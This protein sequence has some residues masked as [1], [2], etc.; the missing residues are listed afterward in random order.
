MAFLEQ[1]LQML[2]RSSHI[3]QPPQTLSALPRRLLGLVMFGHLPAHLLPLV[4]ATCHQLSLSCCTHLLAISKLHRLR[5]GLRYRRRQ[6]SAR[7]AAT[8]VPSAAPFVARLLAESR[9]NPVPEVLLSLRAPLKN[10]PWQHVRATPS[11][12]LMRSLSEPSRDSLA[13]LLKLHDQMLLLGEQLSTGAESAGA[14]HE[15]LREVQQSAALLAAK[16]LKSGKDEA[17]RLQRTIQSKAAVLIEAAEAAGAS[18]EHREDKSH[19]LAADEQL[20][21]LLIISM[22]QAQAAA[23]IPGV[24]FPLAAVCNSFVDAM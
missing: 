13:E 7:D 15:Q 9:T 2:R 14:I 20:H 23:G 4:A 12:F 22:E 3:E 5:A 8:T 19:N 18:S 16:R 17:D 6:Q 1:T 10:N 21:S 24:C 11:S